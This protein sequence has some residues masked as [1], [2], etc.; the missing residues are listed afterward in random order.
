MQV[1][2]QSPSNSG[3]SRYRVNQLP[4]RRGG[5][6]RGIIT[7]AGTPRRARAGNT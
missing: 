5:Q 7:P 1:G 2:S 4:P 6:R 3:S